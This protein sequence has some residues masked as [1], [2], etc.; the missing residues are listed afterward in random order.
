MEGLEF[1]V[2]LDGEMAEEL[3]L[4]PLDGLSTL[5]LPCEFGEGLLPFFLKELAVCGGRGE[6]TVSAGRAREGMSERMYVSRL[7]YASKVFAREEQDRVCKHSGLF[8]R[9]RSGQSGFSPRAF[10]AGHP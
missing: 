6:R 3:G 4:S 9:L 7:K 10:L 1:F 5:V 2:A 8:V